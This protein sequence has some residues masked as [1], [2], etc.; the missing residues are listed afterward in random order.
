M[1]AISDLFTHM[2]LDDDT[3]LDFLINE[4]P[5]SK[6]NATHA[7]YLQIYDT[8]RSSGKYNHQQC[9]IPLPQPLH[10]PAWRKRLHAYHDNIICDYLE[11]GWPIGFIRDTQP[12]IIQSYHAS[13]YSYPDHIHHYVNTELQHRAIPGQFSQPAF[14]HFHISPLMTRPQ[15]NSV[16]DG[17]ARDSYLGE[18]YKLCYPI[19]EDFAALI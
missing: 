14:E 17:I 9:C 15:K 18:N 13:A 11:F 6:T 16:N 5:C 3:T 19:V 1:E 10:I 2:V 8:V 7:E 4:P 12:S